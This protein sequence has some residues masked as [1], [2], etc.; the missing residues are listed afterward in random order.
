MAAVLKI[1]EI[2]AARQ[3]N[4]YN[5]QQYYLPTSLI[6]TYDCCMPI[7]IPCLCFHIAYYLSCHHSAFACI[8]HLVSVIFGTVT[9][10]FNLTHT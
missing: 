9:T 8:L 2:R 5:M 4:I 7:C 6:L 3:E 10:S 1:K